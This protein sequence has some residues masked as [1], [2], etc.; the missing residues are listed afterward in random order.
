MNSFELNKIM[1]AVL[2]TLLFVM[3]IGFLAEAI[4]HPIEDRG[5]GYELPEPEVG[6][7]MAAAEPEPEVPL[8]NLLANASAEAGEGAARKCVSCHTFEEGGANKTGPG[9]YDVVGRPIASHEGYAYSEA[10]LAHSEEDWTYEHLFDF[11]HGP[12]NFAPGSK[13]PLAVP[14]PEERADI[15]AY[16]QTLSA[17]PVPFPE[18][19]EVSADEEVT[20]ADEAAAA[21]PVPEG[22]EVAEPVGEAP[23]PEQVI[24]TPTTLPSDDAIEG[25]PTS[26][27]NP[28]IEETQTPDASGETDATASETEV[29]PADEG[30]APTTNAADEEGAAEAP[31]DDT[32][33]E[34]P[35]EESAPVEE[36]EADQPVAQ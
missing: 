13:M 5:P 9:L 29:A 22:D 36:P 15:L 6:E 2:G 4:Y 16:L 31:V 30:S 1:G 17:N 34:A 23:A 25:M 21:E 27:G 10:L 11:L 32:D 20:E 19:V 24:E 35:V 7:G 26:G 3:G 28:T 8:P 12:Q 14:R 33:A 18:P